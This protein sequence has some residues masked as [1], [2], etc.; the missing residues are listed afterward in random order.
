MCGNRLV[1]CALTE[2][3]RR[4]VSYAVMTMCDGRG[5]GAAGLFEIV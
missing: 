2:G 3:L 4:G 5:M 1:A